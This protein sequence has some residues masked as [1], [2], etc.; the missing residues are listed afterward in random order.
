MIANPITQSLNSFSGYKKDPRIEGTQG[1]VQPGNFGQIG[2]QTAN[3]LNGTANSKMIQ[4]NF[5]GAP[6]MAVNNSIP[7]RNPIGSAF[8][9]TQGSGAN[10]NQV[11]NAISDQI[12]G[13]KITPNQF[14]NI[15]ANKG[16]LNQPNMLQ[17]TGVPINRQMGGLNVTNGITPGMIPTNNVQG[18]NV[19]DPQHPLVQ[20]M[21]TIL[22]LASKLGVGSGPRQATMPVAVTQ[23]LSPQAQSFLSQLSSVMNAQR[24][25]R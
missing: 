8:I 9:P 11:P 22:Q 6:N 21:Q 19:V 3:T 17:R 5:R 23:G 2:A 15:S 1:A 25:I 4:N 18:N 13:S 16:F 14:F 7:Q 24:R 12:K 20:T 10:V